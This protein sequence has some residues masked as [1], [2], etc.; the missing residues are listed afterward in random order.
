MKVKDP[1]LVQ[2]AGLT[3]ATNGDVKM[4]IQSIHEKFKPNKHSR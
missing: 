2:S 1:S 4:H 3:M